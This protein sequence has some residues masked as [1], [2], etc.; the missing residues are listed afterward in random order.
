MDHNR[1]LGKESAEACNLKY[2]LTE[3]SAK[4]VKLLTSSYQ[5]DHYTGPAGGELLLLVTRSATAQHTNASSSRLFNVTATPSYDTRGAFERLHNEK[6][7]ESLNEEF[8]IL[9]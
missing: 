7:I 2:V 4:L 6:E 1:R 5:N 8:L 3:T 9:F